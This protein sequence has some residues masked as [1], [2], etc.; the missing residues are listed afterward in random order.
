MKVLSEKP[1]LPQE[2]R[3][4]LNKISKNFELSF[5]E[6]KTIK[7]FK[8]VPLLDEE[9]AKKLLEELKSLNFPELSPQILI[10][11]VEF[12]PKDIDDL[13]TVLYGITL[14][15]AKSEKILEL[16]NKYK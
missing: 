5:I 8:E 10:K 3:A 15:K 14:D 13:K 6:E 11:L 9:S 7:Y 12:T 4:H 16:I 2:V 1:V